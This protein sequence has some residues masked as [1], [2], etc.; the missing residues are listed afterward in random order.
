[1]LRTQGDDRSVM[2]ELINVADDCR[3][4]SRLC[5]QHALS[6]KWNSAMQVLSNE[7]RALMLEAAQRHR[8][9][10]DY[11][12]MQNLEKISPNKSSAPNIPVMALR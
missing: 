4:F 1:M 11:F 8:L 10:N 12:P 3:L 6:T 5:Q 7:S 9:Q 2:H